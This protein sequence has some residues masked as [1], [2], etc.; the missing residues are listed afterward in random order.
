MWLGDACTVVLLIGSCKDTYMHRAL[1]CMQLFYMT[2]QASVLVPVNICI[3]F[4]IVAYMA[5]VCPLHV[6]FLSETL[7]LLV[8]VLNTFAGKAE[9][10]YCAG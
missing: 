7:V 8:A 6:Y 4:C 5:W 9:E 10:H 1:L 3:F 2:H